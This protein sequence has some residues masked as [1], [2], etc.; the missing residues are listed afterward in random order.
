MTAAGRDD[1][2]PAAGSTGMTARE[3]LMLVNMIVWGVMVGLLAVSA[4]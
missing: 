1:A 2:G 3:K 4:L